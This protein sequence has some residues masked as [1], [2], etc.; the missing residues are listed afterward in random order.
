HLGQQLVTG[1]VA[2]AVVDQL[3]VVQVHIEDGSPVAA[4]AGTRQRLS[5][6]VVEEL[7]VGKAGERVVEGLVPEGLLERLAVGDVPGVEDD[8]CL[9]AALEKVARRHLDKAP[10]AVAPPHP[11]LDGGPGRGLP[12]TAEA[13][14]ENIGC[15]GLIEERDQARSKQPL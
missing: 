12:V 3:E 14:H 1:G 8:A 2:E 10:G 4:P 5:D 15:F 9:L 11:A 7:T 6:T 13:A